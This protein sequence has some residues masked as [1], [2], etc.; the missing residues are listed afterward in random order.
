MG[1]HALVRIADTPTLL[2]PCASSQVMLNARE[3]AFPSKPAVSAEAKD[4]IRRCA[5]ASL[6]CTSVCCL[7]AGQSQVGACCVSV[8]AVSVD[9]A[10]GV[11]RRCAAA[12]LLAFPA[13]LLMLSTPAS[14]PAVRCRWWKA[15]HPIPDPW[16]H[17]LCRRLHALSTPSAICPLST[18]SPMRR[19]LAYRQED[20]LDVHAA[21]AHPYMSFKKPARGAA[22]A[23]AAAKEA[24]S[25][26]AAAVGVAAGR[27]A[28]LAGPVARETTPTAAA[29]L[30]GRG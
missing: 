8:N 14:A 29:G 23:A 13:R 26:V 6:V 16:L 15:P 12:G 9:D 24:A 17:P 21:A 5:C 11:M 30:S 27:E 3:V 10:K 28:G 22:A 4:F 1:A 20:R 2:P 18:S 19:C 25:I 7:V